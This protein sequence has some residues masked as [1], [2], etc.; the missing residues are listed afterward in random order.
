[1][2][3][4]AK[5]R[6]PVN[7]EV[8]IWARERAGYDVDEAASKISVKPTKISDWEA[9]KSK[10]T[11]RQ[12][13]LL[14]KVYERPFLE[15]F[16]KTIPEVQ[17]VDL[18]PDFRF[19]PEGPTKREMRALEAI[20]AWA[21][22][23]RTNALDLIEELGEQPP[24]FSSNLRFSIDSDPEVAASI[25]REALRFSIDE[26][27]SQ[28]SRIRQQ[29]PNILRNKIE[30]MGV[31]VLK[32][33]GL[34][35]LRAR[36]VCLYAEP[37]PVIVFGNE[38]PS[39]QAFTLAHEFGH[40]LIGE[41]AIS[42][43]P[44]LKSNGSDEQSKK[45][46]YWCNGFAAAFMIPVDALESM[47]ARP[48]QPASQFDLSRLSKLADEFAV[49]RHAMLIRLVTLEYVQSDF[50]WTQMRP[51][52]KREEENYQGFG[53]PS[54]YGKRYVNSRGLFYTGLVLDAWSSGRITSHNA[55]EYMGIKNLE[56]LKDIR[57]DF[58]I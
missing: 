2:A 33:G 23:Q 48:T 47:E 16:A 21:E 53:R 28:P 40:I 25:A 4:A 24:V 35:K 36:G 54:Y 42:G 13:R 12:G 15:F 20:Q 51:V 45:V 7:P 43:G 56:H 32:Q 6:L 3:Q 31:L 50:Y 52:F 49:S 44:R 34:T 17:E 9:G 38:A 46:E 30:Q 18:V 58:R 57:E 22:E 39:A 29:M 5:Q 10:P 27:I 37:L 41:S 55:A 1:M 26:Q 14:A 19:Y 11:P 8:L